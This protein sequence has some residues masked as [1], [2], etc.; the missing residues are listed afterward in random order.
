MATFWARP[1]ITY[2]KNPTYSVAFNNLQN[3]STYFALYQPHNS[4]RKII[5]SCLDM[6]CWENVNKISK[7]FKNI[8]VNVETWIIILCAMFLFKTRDK[9]TCIDALGY[10]PNYINCKKQQ[11]FFNKE[12]FII[13]YKKS[14]H[15]FKVNL[16]WCF[17]IK[18]EFVCSSSLIYIIANIWKT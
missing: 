11:H 5:K 12:I 16:N 9:F 4:V 3:A 14:L 15:E 8:P 2:S 1:S 10:P 7:S 6:L 17:I 18:W 13:A